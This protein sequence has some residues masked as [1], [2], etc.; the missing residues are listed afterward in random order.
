[1]SQAEAALTTGRALTRA[2]LNVTV[3]H[4][5]RI[6]D[7]RLAEALGF[8][9]PADIR[10]LIER[11]RG[12]LE[13]LGAIIRTVR[14]SGRG[15]PAAENY[16]T[17]KQALFLCT[18]SETERATDITI[19][20]VEVYDEHTSAAALLPAPATPALPVPDRPGLSLMRVGRRTVLV[21]TADFRITRRTQAVVIAHDG[22]ISIMTVTP[23]DDRYGWQFASV[24]A[25]LGPSR[26]APEIGP[27]VKSR[28]HYV[29]IGRVV[30]E[31]AAA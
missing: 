20:I 3:N 18:K 2:D 13:R 25:A 28:G 15:R 10:A 16:L 27:R 12:A 23:D 21:D 22:R 11:H 17:K 14:K 6:L 9:R 5:P 24:R 8:K 31:R 29:V 1:M 30:E 7:V 4:E 19:E 26:L